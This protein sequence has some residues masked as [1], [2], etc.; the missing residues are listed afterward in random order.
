MRTER[1]QN[2]W[3]T[4]CERHGRTET[5]RRG[6]GGGTSS[7]PDV[8]QGARCTSYLACRACVRPRLQIDRGTPSRPSRC[9]FLESA[10]L[11]YMPSVIDNVG[12]SDRSRLPIDKSLLTLSELTR[13]FTRAEG[14]G[15]QPRVAM[16]SRKRWW[17]LEPLSHHP[18][19]APSPGNPCCAVRC[20][21]VFVPSLQL[22]AGHAVLAS[23][24]S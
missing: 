14:R 20:W 15:D 4:N 6:A 1:R 10:P 17:S 19:A 23:G 16:R 13:A 12:Q 8:T 24:W 21:P 9:P 3:Q 2:V 22:A 11:D 5:R 7:Q 18:P